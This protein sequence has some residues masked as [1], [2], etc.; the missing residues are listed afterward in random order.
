[1][2]FSPSESVPVEKKAQT[3]LVITL[4]E[5]KTD[6]AK[7]YKPLL[8][9]L[10]DVIRKLDEKE[11]WVPLSAVAR[12]DLQGRMDEERHKLLKLQVYHFL[13]RANKY[14]KI[15]FLIMERT[16]A[17]FDAVMKKRGCYQPAMKEYRA[18]SVA[19]PE[20][21]IKGHKRSWA[22]SFKEYAPAFEY[23]S[24]NKRPLA[25][26]EEIF[27]EIMHA[28]VKEASE[29]ERYRKLSLRFAK[30]L[31][32]DVRTASRGPTTPWRSWRKEEAGPD[33]AEGRYYFLKRAKARP[34]PGEVA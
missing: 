7:L 18:L 1:L 5:G 10:P 23:L 8:K 16:R 4:K 22:Y 15:Y 19:L 32:S 20:A 6:K 25:G 11:I 17:R 28:V 24:Q 9:I 13:K 14:K 34:G 3:E 30:V 2:S 27:D 31:R 21:V 29:L 33:D 12:L 26:G